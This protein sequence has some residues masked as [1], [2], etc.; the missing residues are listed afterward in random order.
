MYNIRYAKISDSKILGEIHAKS[1]K[2]AYKNIIPDEFLDNISIEDRS[3][4]FEKSLTEGWE[5]DAI[6]YKNSLPIG[7]ICIGKCRDIDLDNS[8]GEIW[9]IYVLPDYFNLGIGSSLMTWGINELKD[10]GY[11]KIILWVLE[12][13]HNAIKFYEKHGFKFDGTIKEIYLGKSLMECRFVKKLD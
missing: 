3:K 6:I 1:W 11:S 12:K 4:F 7:M 9:G 10:R 5:E 8:S 13:N 2:V